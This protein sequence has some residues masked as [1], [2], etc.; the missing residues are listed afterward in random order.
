M[1]E[2]AS[3]R[4]SPTPSEN[5]LTRI[6]NEKNPKSVLGFEPDLLGQHVTTLPL[7]PP[8]RP[9]LQIINEIQRSAWMQGSIDSSAK[10][11]LFEVW[12]EIEFGLLSFF[13]TGL[14]FPSFSSV[15]QTFGWFEMRSTWRCEVHSSL[16]LGS[17]V[18]L[19]TLPHC[20]TDNLIKI[21][22]LTQIKCLI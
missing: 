1:G 7:A 5:R 14:T 8:P 9:Y 2:Y 20:T 4:I 15:V 21:T 11:N 17:F 19:K 3:F 18:H 22:S 16:N 13:L 6:L 12:V 10:K